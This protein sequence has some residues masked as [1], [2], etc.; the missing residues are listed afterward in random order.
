[1]A[2]TTTRL[3]L[4]YPTGGDRVA[5]GDNAMQALAEAVDTALAGVAWVNMALGNAWTNTDTN[6]YGFASYRKRGDVVELRGLIT[7]GTVGAVIFT[8][9]AGFR[10]PKSVWFL[11]HTNAN[12]NAAKVEILSSGAM[13]IT[14]CATWASLSGITFSTTP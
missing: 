10:P 7:P 4:P 6:T 3:A 5:D 9:P 8:L 2:G 12:P 14:Q 1:M 11:G 13:N